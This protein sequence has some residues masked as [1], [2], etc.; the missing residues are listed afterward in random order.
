MFA[1][2]MKTKLRRLFGNKL[3]ILTATLVIGTGGF[4][5]WNIFKGANNDAAIYK[6]EPVQRRTV[7]SSVNA[8]GNVLSANLIPITTQASGVVSKVYVQEGDKV[9]EGGRIIDITLD[10]DGENS[11]VQQKASYISAK[12]NFESAKSRL[13]SLDNTLRDKEDAFENVKETTSYQTEEEQDMFHD[14]ENDYL[15]AKAD[16]EVQQERIKEAEL[17]LQKALLSYQ[18][19]LP[20]VT[21]PSSG[22]ITGISYIE[23]MRL[24]SELATS[25]SAKSQTI[26]SIKTGGAPLVSVDVSEID[27]PLL[28]VGQKATVI[29]DSIPVKTFTGEVVAVDRVGF[30]TSGVSNYPV[31]LQLDTDSKDVLSNMAATSEIIVDRKENVLAVPS[32]AVQERD[33]QTFVQVLEGGVPRFIAVKTGLESLSRVEIISGLSEGDEVVTST[34]STG[35]VEEGGQSPFGSSSGGMMKMVK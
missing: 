5:I 14:A 10:Q 31:I 26:A 13:Y 33:G 2:N 27:V 9:L 34:L 17:S 16:Y 25:G 7:V 30:I 15:A 6:T 8:S 21:A 12:N 18:A 22:V 19:V 3:V 11:Q 20:Y 24:N 4:L 35:T 23:G 1:H 29:L 32:T 28:E